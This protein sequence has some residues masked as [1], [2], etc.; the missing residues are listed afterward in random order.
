MIWIHLG[1]TWWAMAVQ[2]VLEIQD[3]WQQ[4][5]KRRLLMEI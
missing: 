2:R 1:L 4:K 5:L 3:L